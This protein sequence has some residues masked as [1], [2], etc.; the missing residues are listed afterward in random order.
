M[1]H[2]TRLGFI[3]SML[4]KKIVFICCC[5]R[6]MA[7]GCTNH[8]ELVRVG[9]QFILNRQTTFQCFTGIFTSQH[10]VG[11][12]HAYVEVTDSPG[13]VISKFIIGRQEWMGLAITFNLCCFVER[14]PLA[15]LGNIGF[16]QL[17]TIPLR[18]QRKHNAV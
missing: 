10:I 12:C 14:L 8:P 2:S 18:F 7:V 9:A 6:S 5:K 17:L 4:T 3:T 13:L 11:F 1:A 15:T 16:I